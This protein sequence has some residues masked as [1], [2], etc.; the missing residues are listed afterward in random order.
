MTVQKTSMSKA[1]AHFAEALDAATKGEV[2]LVQRH[3]KPD[4]AIVDADLLE[5]IL[6]ASDASYLRSIKESR[7][8]YKRGEVVSFEEA[9]GD[10]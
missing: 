3:G 7:E 6:A 4:A 2:I 9:F 10:I 1:R 8:Q 5:D